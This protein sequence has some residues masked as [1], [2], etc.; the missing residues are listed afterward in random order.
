MGS[1]GNNSTSFLT[2]R[3]EWHDKYGVVPDYD[4]DT[5]STME[6]LTP[7]QRRALEKELDRFTE[8]FSKFT[9]GTVGISFKRNLTED[10]VGGEYEYGYS[11]VNFTD[12]V[13]GKWN[14]EGEWYGGVFNTFHPKG[15]DAI[16]SVSH[17]LAHAVVD[18]IARNSVKN[19]DD[20]ISNYKS[21]KDSTEKSITDSAAKSLNSTHGNLV[22]HIS[23]YALKN[24]G[25]TIAEAVSD[26]V[27]NRTNANRYSIA[28]VKE[29]KRRLK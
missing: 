4:E 27:A 3:K 20:F 10:S 16:N 26:Y 22:T 6:N 28:I 18:R 19:P 25:E 29:L 21:I 5:G 2:W 24:R 13:F 12:K 7:S 1:V 11:Q 14:D 15:T 17:E 23:G 9:D 8:V